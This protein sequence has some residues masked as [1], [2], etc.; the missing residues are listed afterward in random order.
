MQRVHVVSGHL[1][2]VGYDPE[3]RTLE[4]RF[5]DGLI[6]DYYNVPAHI[7][8]GLMLAAKHGEYFY[9]FVRRAGYRYLKISR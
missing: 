7:H 4:V 2:S 9:R 5:L 3:S 8:S 1:E 6:Y